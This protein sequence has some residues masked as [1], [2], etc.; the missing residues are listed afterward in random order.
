MHNLQL[1]PNIRSGITDLE[2]WAQDLRVQNHEEKVDAVESVKRIKAQKNAVVEFFKDSKHKAHAAW[3]AI[4]AN[5]K[6]FLD[7]LDRVERTAKRAIKNFDEEEERKRQAE[8]RRLQAEADERARRERERLR[9]EAERLKTPELKE[10]RLSQA[11]AIVP[12]TV[13]LEPTTKPVEGQSTRSNWKAELVDFDALVQAAQDPNSVA[14]T[15]LCF[16][17]NAANSFAKS[18]KGN[19][20]VPGVKF[21]DEKVLSIRS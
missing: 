3:K 19:I 1:D 8:Q 7:V 14:R 2:K 15:M 21:K 18:T 16:D 6:K 9:K 13:E 11:E 20:Q 12:P 10:E 17:Q 5:E 4:V